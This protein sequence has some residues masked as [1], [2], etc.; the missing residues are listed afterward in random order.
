MTWQTRYRSYH[1]ELRNEAVE[2]V[3]RQ[4]LYARRIVHD[5]LSAPQFGLA[6]YIRR[7]YVPPEKL[8]PGYERFTYAGLV[9]M[10]NAWWPLELQHPFGCQQFDGGY[11][12]QA[13]DVPQRGEEVLAE[14]IEHGMQL[15]PIPE[16]SSRDR[17]CYAVDGLGDQTTQVVTFDSQVWSRHGVCAS[18]I[19]DH[20]LRAM[21][22]LGVAA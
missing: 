22:E 14:L 4:H 2:Y 9:L 6:E 21:S 13:P 11:Y 16:R 3:L 17:T 8:Y 10:M 12:Y 15:T 19:T 18:R 1:P 20:Y 5:V 7:S